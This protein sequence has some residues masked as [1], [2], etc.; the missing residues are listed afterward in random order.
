MP[1]STRSRATCNFV[2]ALKRE[3]CVCSWWTTV[4][5][6]RPR[7]G[8]RTAPVQRSVSGSL[9]ARYTLVSGKRNREIGELLDIT[10]AIVKCQVSVILRRL[11]VSDRT[12]AVV[13]AL[14]RGIVHI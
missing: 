14:Q 11:D 9:C 4:A 2:S 7:P 1:C 8:G 12:Q 5:G 6:S 13:V 10:E 3:K